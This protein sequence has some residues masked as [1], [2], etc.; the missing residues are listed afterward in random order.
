MRRPSSPGEY[1]P[2]RTNLGP[3][4]GERKRREQLRRAD[5]AERHP[6]NTVE[7]PCPRGLADLD[8]ELYG[9]PS[10]VPV[11]VLAEREEDRRAPTAP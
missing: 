4:A 10:S 3:R 1:R 6:I 7:L 8:P 11:G 2:S 5:I 9:L